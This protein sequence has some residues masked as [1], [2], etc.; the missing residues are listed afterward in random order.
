MRN[1]GIEKS[2]MTS[3]EVIVNSTGTPTGTCSSLISRT[4]SG[5]WMCHI[6]C[7]PI[8]KISVEADGGREF[9]KYKLEAQRKR[10]AQISVG[11][12]VQANSNGRFSAVSPG[13][14]LSARLRYFTMK[15]KIV[16]K[17]PMVKNSVMKVNTK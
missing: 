3:S 13:I 10:P 4:P 16:E 2:G 7:L 9:S 14:S 12:I 17:I 8:T 11:M 15:K 6:H 1:A 5:C